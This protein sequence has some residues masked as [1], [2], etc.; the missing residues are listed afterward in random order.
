VGHI[1]SV[2]RLSQSDGEPGNLQRQCDPGW[3]LHGNAE[4]S[5]HNGESGGG[6]VFDQRAGLMSLPLHQRYRH[7]WSMA[8]SAVRSWSLILCRKQ[9]SQARSG[10]LRRCRHADADA[11]GF[12]RSQWV[13][14]LQLR[15]G[16][17][18]RQPGVASGSAIPDGAYTVTLSYQDTFANPAASASVANVKLDQTSPPAMIAITGVPSYPYGNVLSAQFQAW[19]MHN[20]AWHRLYMFRDWVGIQS[21]IS[22]RGHS[23]STLMALGAVT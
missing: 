7:R 11:G 14:R 12:A 9:P 15:S 4:L 5:G 3:N 16:E 21:P 22:I 1:A 18:N 8:R 20:I 6:R 23:Q 13:A 2:S 19:T 17:S 10:D